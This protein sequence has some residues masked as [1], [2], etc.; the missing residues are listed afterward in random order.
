MGSPL[1]FLFMNPS[2]VGT[3]RWDKEIDLLA[4]VKDDCHNSF[5]LFIYIPGLP[6]LVEKEGQNMALIME[7]PA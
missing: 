6:F 7:R 1:L 4:Y 3:E 2:W 5:L